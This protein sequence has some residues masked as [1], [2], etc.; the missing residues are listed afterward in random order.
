MIPS[1]DA[2]MSIE[3]VGNKLEL[4]TGRSGFRRTLRM[5]AETKTMSTTQFAKSN[6]MI[7]LLECLQ[8]TLGFLSS[9]VNKRNDPVPVTTVPGKMST[10]KLG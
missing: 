10:I 6:R 4:K 3:V 8:L 1:A 5:M 7:K 9:Q 2:I